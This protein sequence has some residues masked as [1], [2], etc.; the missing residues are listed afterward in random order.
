MLCY[1]TLRYTTLR[2]P[3]QHY[4]TQH[5]T[6]LRGGASVRGVPF[7]AIASPAAVLRYTMLYYTSTIL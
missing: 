1:A 4:T 5:Y 6:T 2:Y 7:G 3:T